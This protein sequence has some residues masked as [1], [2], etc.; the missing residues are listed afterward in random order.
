MLDPVTLY[1]EG[2]LSLIVPPPSFSTPPRSTLSPSTD[3]T[4]ATDEWINS[5][6]QSQQRKTTYYD[7][8]LTFY[9]VFTLSSSS[10]SLSRSQ[11][12]SFFLQSL[13]EPHLTLASSLSYYEAA[14]LRPPPPPR[15]QSALTSHYPLTPNPHPS[16]STSTPTADPTTRE[17]VLVSSKPFQQ[18]DAEDEEEDAEEKSKVWVGQTKERNW[19]GVWE[20]H[21]ILRESFPAFLK[22]Q[23]VDLTFVDFQL[24]FR[25][26]FTNRNSPSR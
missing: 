5:L 3:S 8:S 25:L 22:I 1:N 23:V 20:F 19:V 26:H 18:I 15:A 9:L 4:T 11:A 17:S 10:S 13:S 21:A 14:A 16:T 7:E 12:H 24:S 2:Q 6:L